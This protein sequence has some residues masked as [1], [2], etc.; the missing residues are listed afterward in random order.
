MSKKKDIWNQITRNLESKI[1]KPDFNTWFSRTTLE[2]LGPDHAVIGVPNKYVSNWLQERYLEALKKAFKKVL[3][4]EPTIRFS[5]ENPHIN[6]IS[7]ASIP[8]EKSDS[9]FEHYLDPS[10]TFHRFIMGKGNRFAL[11]SAME[12]AKGPNNDYNP[13]YIYCHMAL[14]KTHLLHAIGNYIMSQDPS[15]RVKYLSSDTFTA[16][17]AN[18]SKNKKID[19]F[20]E[21]YCDLDVLLFDDVHLLDNRKRSQE[22]FLFIFN[23]LYGENKRVVIAGQRT[24][25]ELKN[26]NSQLKSRLGSGLI[27]EIQVLD[28]KTKI[29]IIKNLAKEER[30]H[31]P[32]D[33]VFFL[34]NTHNDLKTLTKSVIKIGTYASLNQRDI[35]I[36]TVKSFMKGKNKIE[37]DID[38]IKTITAEY[39]NISLSDLISNKKR[40]SYS[41]PR[42]LAMY[43]ARKYTRLSFKEIGASFGNKDH[44]TVIYAA[45]RIEK[46]KNDKTVRDDLMKIENLLG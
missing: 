44:S 30:I 8:I 46:S 13:F 32:E 43:L 39:F 22:E 4:Q 38:D 5:Y 36:S 40:R 1:S 37:I 26:V 10:M 19:D 34:A 31:I 42:Q 2:E 11:T 24:P 9:T 16:D 29:N 17:F 21:R 41:R 20:R 35:N 28:Q 6:K 27:T 23:A 15:P 25:T 14:G 45:R 33:V 3:K 18:A 7:T 12:V